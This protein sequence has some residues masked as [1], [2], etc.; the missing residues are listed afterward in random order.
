MSIILYKGDSRSHFLEREPALPLD[1]LGWGGVVMLPFHIEGDQAGTPG[2]FS[3]SVRRNRR[4]SQVERLMFS[5]PY[6]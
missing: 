5:R 6:T 4:G 2:S 1:V 3:P